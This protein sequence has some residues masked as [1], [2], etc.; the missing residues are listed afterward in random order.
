R[1]V[2]PEPLRQRLRAGL[3]GS[4]AP[5]GCRTKEAPLAPDNQNLQQEVFLAHEPTVNIFA[6]AGRRWYCSCYGARGMQ[7]I[8][9][10]RRWRVQSRYR[11]ASDTADSHRQQ[12]R[13][14]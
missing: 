2:I 1:I 10:P 11:P 7:L 6:P 9:K 13:P 8:K 12:S 5:P 3:R 4:A 14:E